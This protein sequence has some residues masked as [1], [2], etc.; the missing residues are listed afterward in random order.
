[1]TRTVTAMMMPMDMRC[2]C[3]CFDASIPMRSPEIAG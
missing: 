3:V 1:M 2:M